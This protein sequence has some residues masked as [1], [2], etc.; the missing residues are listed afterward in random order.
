VQSHLG[1][2]SGPFV[3]YRISKATNNAE[4]YKK[5]ASLYAFMGTNRQLQHVR[6]AKRL[7]Y[8]K[9]LTARKI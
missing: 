5:I 6:N 3:L 7:L 8:E 2:K 4:E 1:R 9:K